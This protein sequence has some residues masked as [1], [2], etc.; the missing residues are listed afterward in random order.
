MA[1][2]GVRLPINDMH[3]ALL[4]KKP[5]HAA[6]ANAQ[7]NANGRRRLAANRSAAH[8]ANRTIGACN[9]LETC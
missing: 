4:R 8:E 9:L 5:L 3:V 2:Y 1:S 7:G 6:V